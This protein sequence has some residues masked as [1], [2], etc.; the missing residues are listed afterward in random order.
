[1]SDLA[2]KL[3]E[4]TLGG[5]KVQP[6]A[7]RSSYFNLLVYG[8]SGVGKTT[9][10]G[11]ASEVP[12]LSPVLFIDIEGGTLSLRNSYPNVDVVRV[13]TW[14]KMQDVYD[15]LR[16]GGSGYKTVVLDS[17][18]EIQK[19]SMYGIMEELVRKEPDRDP[20]VPGMRE[21]GKNAEQTRKFV[22]G[23]RDLPLNTIFTALAG[24]DKDARTGMSLT[25]PAMNGK[26]RDEVTAFLDIVVYYYIK[27]VDNIDRR[28]LLTTATDSQTAKDRTGI[29][30]SVVEE[31]TMA[32][33][34]E[35]MTNTQE[36]ETT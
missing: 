23:F 29:L 19:F 9:L 25:K 31:P 2:E 26:V 34:Y 12:E 24:N 15:E 20:D 1:M 5:L 21:W 30:P 33:L 35:Y 4:R 32:K 7:D 10:A 6:V 27:R 3:T 8:P 14:S 22:R 18:T 13:Q 36:K 11:S 17:L 28:L 16:R